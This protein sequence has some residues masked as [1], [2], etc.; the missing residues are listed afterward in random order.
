MTSIVIA[1]NGKHLTPAD[2]YRIAEILIGNAM[3]GPLAGAELA[4]ERHQ[5]VLL[6]MAQIHATLAM[7]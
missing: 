1:D 4:W 7:F 5:D 6:R 3:E 2:H